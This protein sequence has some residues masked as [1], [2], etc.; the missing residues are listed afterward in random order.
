MPTSPTVK[1][2]GK[3]RENNRGP[4]PDFSNS[5]FIQ[6]LLAGIAA[7]REAAVQPTT[8]TETTK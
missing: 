5:S 1:Q 7:V 2:T 6:N 8:K 4:K 3:R